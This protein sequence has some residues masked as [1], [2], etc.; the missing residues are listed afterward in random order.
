MVRILNADAE[1]PSVVNFTWDKLKRRMNAF[2][3]FCEFC[4]LPC[5]LVVGPVYTPLRLVT[6]TFHLR[7]K[8]KKLAKEIK[9]I[10]LHDFVFKL[11]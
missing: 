4:E 5:L 11:P 9:R 10:L 6:A 7:K 2:S 3:S 8:T 1:V